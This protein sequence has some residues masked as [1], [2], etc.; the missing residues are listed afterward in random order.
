MPPRNVVKKRQQS[1]SSISNSPSYM[2]PPSLS[3]VH[4]TPIK[5]LDTSRNST[6]SSVYLTCNTPIGG[7]SPEYVHTEIESPLLYHEEVFENQQQ[8]HFLQ[9]HQSEQ[10][11]SYS[12]DY[13]QLYF[14]QLEQKNHKTADRLNLRQTQFINSSGS[15]NNNLLSNE[16][17][18]QSVNSFFETSPTLN[19]SVPL[20]PPQLPEKRPRKL[21][22]ICRGC[23]LEIYSKCVFSRNNNLLSGKWHKK[24]FCCASCGTKQFQPARPAAFNT[25]FIDQNSNSDNEFYVLNNNP[26]CHRC[27]H[28]ANSSLCT[29]CATGIEGK[30]LDDGHH[31]Y[32]LHC[33]TCAYCNHAMNSNLGSILLTNG[34]VCCPNH[35]ELFS[36]NKNVEKRQTSFMNVF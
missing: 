13:H 35:P 7:S 14:N 10:Q 5:I 22:G 24:C 29:I 18:Y 32:H 1:I 17:L 25:A 4:D 3:T 11:L 20:A 21:K 9:K 6:A 30:Y 33:L 28:M 31:K 34:Q 12:Y 2:S 16:Y 27:Y 19:H 15:P 26:L 8:N 23:H 36:Y